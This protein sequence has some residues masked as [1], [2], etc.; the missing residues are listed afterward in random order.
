MRLSYRLAAAALVLAALVLAACNSNDPKGNRTAGSNRPV[1]TTA[2]TNPS[3]H[4]AP[5]DG[6]K[7]VTTIELRDALNNGTAIIVDV[8][9]EQNYQQNHIKGS[10]SIPLEQV[11]TRYGE[12]PRDK[13]IVTYCS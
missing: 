9:P 2:P 1:V 12:L 11:A 7:R 6:V 8:R 5:P 4:V 10:I 13:T 3:A